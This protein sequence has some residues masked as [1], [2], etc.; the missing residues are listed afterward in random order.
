MRNADAGAV[1]IVNEDI[2]VPEHPDKSTAQAEEYEKLADAAV[3]PDE[4]KRL[5]ELARRARNMAPSRSDPA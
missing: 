3:D 4:K 2:A 1:V 5:Q